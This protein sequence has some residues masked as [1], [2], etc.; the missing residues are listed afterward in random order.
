MRLH[1]AFGNHA[2]GTGC[3]VC[4]AFEPL[5]LGP[6]RSRWIT[7]LPPFEMNECAMFGFGFWGFGGIIVVFRKKR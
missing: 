2:A 4:L 1:R 5:P 6:W 3:E 7:C